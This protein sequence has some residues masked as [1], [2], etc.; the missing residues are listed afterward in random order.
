MYIGHRIGATN[1]CSVAYRSGSYSIDS[2][3]DKQLKMT[4]KTFSFEKW[5][6]VLKQFHFGWD[7]KTFETSL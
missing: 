5:E 4:P 7:E 1:V 2:F 6:N 3:R